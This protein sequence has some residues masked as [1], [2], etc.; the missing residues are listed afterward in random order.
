MPFLGVG[1]GKTKG[2]RLEPI[3]PAAIAPKKSAITENPFFG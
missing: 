3:S 1:S 2:K